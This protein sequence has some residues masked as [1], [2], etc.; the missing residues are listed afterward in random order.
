VCFI[1]YGLLEKMD[2]D[3]VRIYENSKDDKYSFKGSYWI[4]FKDI[5]KTQDECIK[6]Y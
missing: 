5:Y 1:V 4:H 6:G 3:Y 2:N